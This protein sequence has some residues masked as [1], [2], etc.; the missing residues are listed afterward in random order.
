[1]KVKNKYVSRGLMPDLLGGR[2]LENII[3]AVKQEP[4]FY[5]T[6]P[7]LSKV[8]AGELFGVKPVLGG[9]TTTR[10][11]NFIEQRRKETIEVNRNAKLAWIEYYKNKTPQNF[12]KAQEVIL[13]ISDVKTRTRIRKEA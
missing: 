9:E 7:E 10:A 1:M 6:K 4:T 8:L 13:K 11:Y 2:G 12:K 5:G 3:K